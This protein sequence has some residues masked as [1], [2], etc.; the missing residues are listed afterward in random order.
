MVFIFENINKSE[1]F[2]VEI[3]LFNGVLKSFS[4]NVFYIKITKYIF[5]ISIISK[6]YY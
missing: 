6:M 3:L 2:A 5:Y 4:I 1:L